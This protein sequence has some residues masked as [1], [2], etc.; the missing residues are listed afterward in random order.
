MKILLDTQILVWSLTDQN[1][2]ISLPR[3]LAALEDRRNTIYVTPISVL[4]W[5]IK[6][7]V[8]R[9]K[10]IPPEKG[11]LLMIPGLVRAIKENEYSVHPLTLSA[12]MAI[13][14]LPDLHRDPFDRALIALAVD[15]GALLCTVDGK[16]DQYVGSVPSFKVLS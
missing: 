11:G 7:E 2:M 16:I 12:A 6:S 4:E 3:V 15:L 10:N 14:W 8:T 1:K 5:A 9:R 13:E